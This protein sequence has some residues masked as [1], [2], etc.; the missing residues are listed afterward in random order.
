MPD[1]RV[2]RFGI[3]AAGMEF[4][5]G[6]FNLEIDYIGLE[7]NANHTEKFAYEMYR[8]PSFIVGT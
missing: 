5:D 6:E 4:M 8:V 3:T 7:F 2:S 1:F